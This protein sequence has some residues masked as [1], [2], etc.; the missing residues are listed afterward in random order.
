MLRHPTA[1]ALAKYFSLHDGMTR[2]RA[3]LSTWGD[4]VAIIIS[5]EDFERYIDSETAFCF[6]CGETI[7]PYTKGNLRRIGELYYHEKCVRG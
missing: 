7:R 3:A 5:R 1:R 2:F 6:K 4:E